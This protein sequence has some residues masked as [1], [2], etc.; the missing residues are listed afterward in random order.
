MSRSIGTVVIA[1]QVLLITAIELEG[2]TI[3][4]TAR[5]DCAEA[6]IVIGLVEPVRVH[7]SDGQ[8]I[9]TYRCRMGEEMYTVH[10]GDMLT[11][12]LPWKITKVEE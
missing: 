9:G 10:P 5:T 8:S 12:R 2:G 3:V 11:V 4:F 6:E 7:G 1:G